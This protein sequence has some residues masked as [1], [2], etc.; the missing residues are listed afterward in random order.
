MCVRHSAQCL[1]QSK[2]QYPLVILITGHHGNS[3]NTLLDRTP[4][5]KKTGFKVTSNWDLNPFVG[6]HRACAR[7][8]TG[9]PTNPEVSH[10]RRFAQTQT[11]PL[12]PA[13]LPLSGFCAPR[14]Y[15]TLPACPTLV[16]GREGQREKPQLSPAFH[17]RD[18]LCCLPKG[19]GAVLKTAGDGWGEF[20]GK[21]TGLSGPR[22]KAHTGSP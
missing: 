8:P 1:A 6:R 10:P 14:G 4:S 12:P 16:V 18:L 7:A 5:S 2:A 3:T 22:N 19:V 9:T 20:E 17:A 13:R 21:G 15:C 11:V